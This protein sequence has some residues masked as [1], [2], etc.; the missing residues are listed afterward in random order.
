MLFFLFIFMNLWLDAWSNIITTK[1]TRKGGRDRN[2]TLSQE[3][4]KH[5]RRTGGF[6]GH[7]DTLDSPLHSHR[8]AAG[9]SSTLTSSWRIASFSSHAVV[10]QKPVRSWIREG[11]ERRGRKW[12]GIKQ[13]KQELSVLCNFSTTVFT[14]QTA[15]C[16]STSTHTSRLYSVLWLLFN[17]FFSLTLSGLCAKVFQVGTTITTTTC[18]VKKETA[19]KGLGTK[20]GGLT[21]TVSHKR[22]F[23]TKSLLFTK[24]N[25]Y[26]F[27]HYSPV[28][29][30]F[31]LPGWW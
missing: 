22:R 29:A 2:R 31:F 30:S 20:A 3:K 17:L 19:A 23:N 10:T 8:Q 15:W 27:H 25:S 28:S 1:T 7:R 4:K 18:L 5:A 12:D 9:S 26:W 6:Y 11:E 21:R 13:R 24:Y 16:F 14:W